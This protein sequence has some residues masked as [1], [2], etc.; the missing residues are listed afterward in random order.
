MTN[1]ADGPSPQRAPRTALGNALRHWRT[2]RKL[3]G[4]RWLK[5]RQLLWCLWLAAAVAILVVAASHLAPGLRA[6]RGQ[7]IRGEW[8]AGQC[9]SDKNS[10]TWYGEFVLPDG[11]VQLPRVIYTGALT[12]VH[13]GWTT[14]ALNT[15]AGDEVYPLHGS[16]RWV[17]DVIGVAGCL[18]V[19][20]FLIWRSVLV[21]LRRRRLR[22][23]AFRPA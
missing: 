11:K 3:S 5:G 1:L 7:G 22:L 20:G 10:C 4:R 9:V 18:I 2:V 15:G 14:P 12:S 13:P 6:A 16:E 8:I 21:R 19:I 23:G 17:H